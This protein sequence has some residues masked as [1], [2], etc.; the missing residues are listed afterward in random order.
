MVF[1]VG[2]PILGLS[3]LLIPASVFFAYSFTLLPMAGVKWFVAGVVLLFS[4]LNFIS[5]Y[6]Q[7]LVVDGDELRLKTLFGSKQ[8]KLSQLQEIGT[9]VLKMRIVLVLSDDEKF[10]FLSSHLDKFED[11]LDYMKAHVG[12]EL[13]KNI[14]KLDA[15]MIKKKKYAFMGLLVVVALFLAGSG[16]YN[17][18]NY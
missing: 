10:M 1:K 7:R 11:V 13:H 18:I 6:V 14:D 9:V 4:V 2:K 15:G 16:I 8:I 12:K 17:F 5:L 3:F